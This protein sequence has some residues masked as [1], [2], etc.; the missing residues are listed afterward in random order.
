[1]TT[2]PKRKPRWLPTPDT[3]ALA[4]HHAAKP[5]QADRQ[6]VLQVLGEAFKA[7]RQG[8]ATQL[9][10]SI[11]SGA[12]ETAHA[13]ERKGIVRG[14]A[15]HLEAAHIVLH[16]IYRRSAVNGTWVAPTLHYQELDALS[17]FV[18]LHTY[19]V[20]QLGRAELLAA[21][22]AAANRIKTGG[23]SVCVLD[24]QQYQQ[25]VAA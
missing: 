7:L 20:N 11:L 23:G 22:D 19:Q 17:T 8:V 3:L 18:D 14:L 2:R 5:S 12:L 21:I 6:E 4:L 1:M 25:Q 10:W 9:Q 13:I 16:T 15:G 24:Q